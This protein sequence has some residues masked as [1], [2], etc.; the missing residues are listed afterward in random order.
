MI[1]S[2]NVSVHAEQV[3]FLQL[4]EKTKQFVLANIDVNVIN[5]GNKF[6][7]FVFESMQAVAQN[8]VFEHALYRTSDREFPDIIAKGYWGVEVKFTKDDKWLS[9]GNSI[10]ESSRVSSVEKIY[11]FFG[12]CGGVPEIK[13]RRYEDCLS[14]ISV[15]H[16]P[17]YQIDMT[18]AEG[19][20]I[21]DKIGISYD[22]LRQDKRPVS[23]IRQYYK[24]QLKNNDSL[25]WIDEES[26][27][28]QFAIYSFANLEQQQKDKLIAESFILFPEILSNKQDKYAKACAF[29]VSYYSVICPNMRDLYSAGGKVGLADIEAEQQAY[30]QQWQ[31]DKLSQ[32][33]YRLL[34]QYQP[35]IKS[36]LGN[37]DLA[38]VE[39]C[40]NEQMAD[41]D[42]LVKKWCSKIDHYSL[43]Q[44]FPFALSQMFMAVKPMSRES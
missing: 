3:L 14:G 43:D 35:I 18:L 12:K 15:T 2:D 29:W 4:L 40:W 39:D 44:R 13:Y 20:S 7:Q 8:T 30:Y 28:K 11:I 1:Y 23:K 25:W 21:F 41:Y 27:A 16:Y 26:T 24:K 33:F 32:V 5:S 17:R 34:F 42:S 37:I 31:I 36:L 38:V 6:E 22:E 9:I 10:L 19:H